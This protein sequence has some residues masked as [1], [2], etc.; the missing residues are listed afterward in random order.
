MTEIILFFR[1]LRRVPTIDECY[2]DDVICREE[3]NA[4]FLRDR[5]VKSRYFLK[6]KKTYC[7]ELISF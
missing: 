7:K 3:A 5:K 2:V 6:L 4:Q 1:S